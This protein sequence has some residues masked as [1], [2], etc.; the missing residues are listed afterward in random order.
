[1]NRTLPEMK[2]KQL[3]AE[4]RRQDER[5]APSFDAT[6]HSCVARSDVSGGT[7]ILLR[8]GLAA[9]LI[10]AAVVSLSFYLG[11]KNSQPQ[12]ILAVSF[13]VPDWPSPTDVWLK[14]PGEEF[15]KTLPRLGLTALENAPSQ[16]DPGITNTK[17]NL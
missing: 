1:M 16:S 12:T 7:R 3:F 2:L 14:T 9:A 10:I 11:R 5:R 4:L 8:I 6:W 13:A 15:L 17:E